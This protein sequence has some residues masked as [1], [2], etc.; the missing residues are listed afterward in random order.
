MLLAD[1][2]I[3]NK[4]HI[5]CAELMELINC[6]LNEKT[7]KVLLNINLLKN[8]NKYSKDLVLKESIPYLKDLN[9]TEKLQTISAEIY[10][11]ILLSSEI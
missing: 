8:L 10:I 6:I 7:L 9:Q 2:T 11:S 3:G 1:V 5:C 4:I